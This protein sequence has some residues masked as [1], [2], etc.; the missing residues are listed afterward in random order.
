M[1]DHLLPSGLHTSRKL[2]QKWSE[3][4]EPRY[5]DAGVPSG[6]FTTE[7]N[8]YPSGGNIYTVNHSV[9]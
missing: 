7:P 8:A 6:V 2:H 4:L 9:L 5:T 1:G 3:E